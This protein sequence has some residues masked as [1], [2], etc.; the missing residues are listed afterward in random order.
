MCWAI[1]QVLYDDN[2]FRWFFAD[3]PGW[4]ILQFYYNGWS[5]Y[6]Y[7]YVSGPSYWVSPNP[8]PS[9]S[10]YP[11]PYPYSYDEEQMISVYNYPSP[12]QGQPY[13][14]YQ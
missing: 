3:V 13:N 1:G 4:H 9:P 14:P 10:P 12:P 8:S 6:A 2:L 11:Y 7:I 5:N